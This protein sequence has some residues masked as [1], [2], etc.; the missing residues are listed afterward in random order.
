[1]SS[2]AEQAVKSS[3]LRPVTDEYAS[4]ASGGQ[5]P[6]ASGAIPLNASSAVTGGVAVLKVTSD[7]EVQPSKAPVL[8]LA[9]EA[10]ISTSRNEVQLLNV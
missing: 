4:Y 2:M 10:D 5:T 8:M 6:L 1:M 9:S 3:G 7:R